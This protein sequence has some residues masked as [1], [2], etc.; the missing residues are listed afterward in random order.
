MRAYIFLIFAIAILVGTGIA[1]NGET[2]DVVAFIQALEQD[3]FTVQQGGLGHFDFMKLYDMGV[4]PSALGSNPATKYLVYL[5][6][7]PWSRGWGNYF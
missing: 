7:P 4:L 2:G 5:V 3:G 6:P 1:E